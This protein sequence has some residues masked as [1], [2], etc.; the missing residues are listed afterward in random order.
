VRPTMMAAATRADADG[1]H[2][3]A[4]AAEVAVAVGGG[5]G[6]GQPFGGDGAEVGEADQRDGAADP[7]HSPG[8]AESLD[9]LSEGLEV[10]G[11]GVWLG[12]GRV[13]AVAIRNKMASRR[14]AVGAEPRPT[15]VAAS[16]GPATME[17]CME[18]AS[19]ELA[20]ARWS[21]GTS[22]AR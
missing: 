7:A 14:S 22:S 19:S 11:A 1:G 12:R 4:V 6:Q 3:G 10:L 17:V 8:G 20:A 16:A 21:W 18:T 15:R 9:G 13:V 5:L 2:D